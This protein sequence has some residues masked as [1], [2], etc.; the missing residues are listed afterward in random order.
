MS[1]LAARAEE[2]LRLR[3]ALGFKLV[4]AGHLL[5]QFAAFCD[6]AGAQTITVQ[7]G[8]DWARLP[9]GVQPSLLGAAAR[10][11]ARVCP[12]AGQHRPGN[13]DPAARRV[14]RT[15][16]TAHPLHLHPARDRGAAAGGAAA[17]PPLRAASYE[18]LLGL[19][20]ATGMR[21][22]E[23]LSASRAATSTWPPGSSPSATP[24]SAGNGCCRCTPASPTRWPTTPPNATGY[25]PP[26]AATRSLLSTGGI[27]LTLIAAGHT[28]TRLTTWTGLRTDTCSP[29]MH[30]LR[31]TM[32]VRTL[33]DWY[34]HTDNRDG[35]IDAL[36]PLLSTLSRSRL[37]G[38]H[39]LVLDRRPG[40]DAAGRRTA[41]R[42]GRPHR[43]SGLVS[44]L[45]PLL[46]SFFTERLVGQRRASP[47]TIAGYRDTFRL[48]LPLR[49]R[50]H[51]HQP[52]PHR[53]R[54]TST[55]R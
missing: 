16:A 32:A 3:R 33:I 52:S 2:Y 14:R 39:I 51:R 30:D 36:L 13:S 27:A 6:A 48:L 53:H 41:T 28:F 21:V 1:T 47:H 43:G 10:C 31:H 46:Q 4:A 34:R 26:R 38:I 40:L 18:A 44:A 17:A 54:P 8:V 9:A 11:G 7:R 42:T 49:R 22:C 20:A 45:A 55:P 37:A 24:N 29:R 35:R 15:P 5:P 19:L 25:A 12:L 50:P 23:A